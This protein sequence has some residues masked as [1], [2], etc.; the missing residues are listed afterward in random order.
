ME[1]FCAYVE[2]SREFGE[3]LE[4]YREQLLTASPVSAGPFLR[5]FPDVA[6]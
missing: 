4:A 3:A 1:A 5:R 6:I 2:A